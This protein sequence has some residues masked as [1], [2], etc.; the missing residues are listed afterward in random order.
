M[1]FVPASP[2]PSI[3]QSA[4]IDFRE[5]VQKTSSREFPITDIIWISDLPGLDVCVLRVARISGAD[6]IDPPI[7]L[8]T[9]QPDDNAMLAV[10]GFPGSNNGYD[11]APFQKLFGS[12][13]GNK[14]FSPG[15]YTGRS[16]GSVTYD[17]STLPGSSGSVVLDV[18]SGRAVGLH[19]AGTALLTNYA[20]PAADIAQIIARQPWT[21]ETV[22]PRPTMIGDDVGS[23]VGGGGGVTLPP[24]AAL[25]SAGGGDGGLSFV[26]PL[27]ITVKLGDQSVTAGV[28][29]ATAPPPSRT[30]RM[31]AEAAAEKVRQHLLGSKSVLSIKA[32]YLFRDGV[33]TDDYGVVVGIAPGTAVDPAALGLGNRLDGVAI[34]V[35]T[36][37]P[38]TIADQMFAYQS[39]AFGGRVAKYRRDRNDPRFKLTPVTDDMSILLH[40]SPE[41]GW[42]VLKDFLEN[43]SHKRLTIGMYHMTAPHVVK[44]IE[45]IAERDNT[46]ITLTIDRQRGEADNPDDIG[47]DS[48]G[49]KKRND[50]PEEKTLD[51]LEDIA[52]SR[53]NWAPASLG[54]QGLFASAYHIKVAVWGD[55]DSDA[56]MFWLSSGNWQSSNQDPIE[57]GLD[58]IN[59][60]R[61]DQVEG[62]NREWHAVV[63]HQGLA[64]TFRNHLEQDFE[65]N[66]RIAQQE[67]PAPVMPDVLVPIGAREEAP[68][69]RDF[70]AFPPKLISGNIKVQ[71]LLTPDNYPEII[72]DLISQARERVWIE[73]QSFNFWKKVESMPRHFLNI[74]EAVRDQQNRGRDVRIIFRDG[75]GKERETLRQM[76]AFGLKTDVDHV[77]YFDK[78]HTKGFVID[79]EIAVLG[80]H[81]ITAAG[82]G[83]NR[84]ASLVIWNREANQY[85][86]ELFQYDWQQIGR[87]RARRDEGMAPMRFVHARDE[88]PAPSGYRRISMAEF[89]G[90]T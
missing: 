19:F 16:D 79:D 33:L 81:N 26:V 15:F 84:D 76:K 36:A 89:L 64:K 87:R 66:H 11:P 28:Q 1:C 65:D 12:V 72:A 14:R 63:T 38:A 37:D 43:T 51:K 88:A 44:A 70:K 69:P 53:F 49:N 21:G 56:S 8:M 45:E 23:V 62:Y 90:E 41:A 40:V 9:G 2:T 32:N 42:P 20:V 77:R 48:E 13:T 78:C 35:E 18:V 34:S 52:G 25:H 4:R 27:T 86:A 71:P 6:R 46:K 80:S 22:S 60:V 3:R 5:E 50:I 47:E 68:S 10:V 31:S 75:F 85:F 24:G 73:N 57:L 83:P 55:G 67:A 58:Q 7:K 29:R 39:E 17:C 30:D 54:A 61:P 82:V 74:A 59:Q